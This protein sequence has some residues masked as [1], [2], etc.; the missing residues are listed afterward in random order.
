V[1]AAVGAHLFTPLFNWFNKR[2][3]T[4]L[5]ATFTML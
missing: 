4:G 2:M 1:A 3:G 5:S